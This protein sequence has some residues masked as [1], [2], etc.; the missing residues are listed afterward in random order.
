MKKSILA[1]I[2]LG[3]LAITGSAL[4]LHTGTPTTEPVGLLGSAFTDRQNNYLDHVLYESAMSGDLVFTVSPA[5]VAPAPT[6][7]AWT[8]TVTVT[9]ETAAG[10]DH[11][12]FDKA[13]TTGVSIADTS[14]AG[15]ASIPSTTLT[16]VDGV[17]TVVVSGD[18]ADWLDTETDTLTVAQ[19]TILGYTVAAKTSVETFTA[20]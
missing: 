7:S 10:A 14:T 17:A 20:P 3:L 2:V 16:F 11:I 8:R 1:F 13:I 15:T 12:W 5:T 9:L 18:A 19:A 6:S 4:A